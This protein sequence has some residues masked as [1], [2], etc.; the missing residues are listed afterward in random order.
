MNYVYAA[1]IATIGSFTLYGARLVVR[2]R[3]IAATLLRQS[4]GEPDPATDEGGSR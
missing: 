3:Q 2:S 4:Q 1:Y